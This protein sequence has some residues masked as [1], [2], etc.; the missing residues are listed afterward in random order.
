MRLSTLL[1]A[2]TLPALVPDRRRRRARRGEQAI[3]PSARRC[4]LKMPSHDHSLEEAGKN[5]VGGR[6]STALIGPRVRQ[7]SGL[8][9]LRRDEER[10]PDLGPGDAGQIPRQTEGSGARH[11]D[12]PSRPA[13][14]KD[15]ADLIT[16]LEQ[17]AGSAQ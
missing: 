3:Q 1:L 4:S 13:Q 8:Q 16:Y 14:D 9:L 15:R 10:A 5:K 6:R 17:A 12:D 7:R 2:A 11:Q